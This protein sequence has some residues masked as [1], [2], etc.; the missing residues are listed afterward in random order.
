MN[1][2]VDKNWATFAEPFIFIGTMRWISKSKVSKTAALARFHVENE[3]ILQYNQKNG[4][5]IL[6]LRLMPT[7]NKNR[8]KFQEYD[9]DDHH[10]AT[11]LRYKQ[12]FLF[13]F[14]K[15]YDFIIL[16]AVSSFHRNIYEYRLHSLVFISACCGS[17]SFLNSMNI[18]RIFV[19]KIH[20][21]K[22]KFRYVKSHQQ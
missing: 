15:F 22:Q 12:C 6:S 5:W 21:V 2:S 4:P 1:M 17:M 7:Y 10:Q 16:R 20:F 13:A 8:N 19:N 14:M 18:D 11:S 9:D 3:T